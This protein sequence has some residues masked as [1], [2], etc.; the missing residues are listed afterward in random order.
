MFIVSNTKT[1][2]TIETNLLKEHISELESK[3]NFS[4]SPKKSE[5]KFSPPS[6]STINSSFQTNYSFSF[7]S[8]SSFFAYF[9]QEQ[10]ILDDIQDNSIKNEFLGKKVNYFKVNNITK[11]KEQNLEIKKKKKIKNSNNDNNENNSIGDRIVNEGRWNEEENLRFMEAI[12]NYGNDWKEVKNYVRTRTSNQ[13]RSH[14]QK[15]ILKIKTFKDD[16][17]GIDFTNKNIKNLIDIVNVIKEAKE[18]SK[19][20]NILVLLCQ[21]LSE[22]YL[23]NSGNGDFFDLNDNNKNIKKYGK[24]NN[25]DK[26]IKNSDQENTT[27]FI[28]KNDVNIIEIENDN[29][30]PEIIID[31]KIKKEEK[32]KNEENNNNKKEILEEEKNIYYFDYDNKNNINSN[33]YEII[34]DIAYEINTN[35][36]NKYNIKE[37]NTI[38]II[39]NGYFS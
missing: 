9:N 39:N 21:K 20:G 22:K 11:K 36:L 27:I 38:S 3:E 33:N 17:I 13:V 16:S 14:A 6:P 30:K 37:F 18:V 1:N 35:L 12:Y 2:K 4:D 23:K 24:A 28:K 32:I 29:K 5:K 31:N 19:K 8:K 34:N 7:S 25:E 26:V 10:N 15:F